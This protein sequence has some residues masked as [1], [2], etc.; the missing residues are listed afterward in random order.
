VLEPQLADLA[1]DPLPGTST[2]LVRPTKYDCRCETP[3]LA[4][5]DCVLTV[6]DFALLRR[7]LKGI[8]RRAESPAPT[9]QSERPVPPVC[10][11]RN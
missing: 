7:T 9:R 8:A 4:L 3:V 1:V 5:F 11:D 2:R 10:A 6:I